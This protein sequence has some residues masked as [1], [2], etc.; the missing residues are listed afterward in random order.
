MG[1]TERTIE[2]KAA[3]SEATSDPT[4]TDTTRVD[5]EENPET[6]PPDPL[7]FHPGKFSR[8]EF[9][10]EV[11]QK[12][13]QTKLPRLGPECFLDTVPP[14]QALEAPAPAAEVDPVPAIAKPHPAEV[15]PTPVIVKPRPQVGVVIVCLLGAVLLL[16]LAIVRSWRGG[17][18]PKP[19]V[20]TPSEPSIAPTP[21]VVATPPEVVASPPPVVSASPAEHAV[22][23]PRAK[24]TTGHRIPAPPSPDPLPVSKPTPPMQP[25][26]TAVPTVPV[27]PPPAAPA[28]AAPVQST[29]FEYK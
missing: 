27:A 12:M 1:M 4:V 6:P 5:P 17:P 28:R 8:I 22:A 23:I 16:G 7:A 2:L 9:S 18:E 14:N 15:E 20:A 26:A 11:R 13:L 21:V 29:W 25:D 3:A 24:G 10:D 19:V